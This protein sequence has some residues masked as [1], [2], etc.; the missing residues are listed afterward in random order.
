MH[1]YLSKYKEV[2]PWL[3]PLSHTEPIMTLPEKQ[4]E[5]TQ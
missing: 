1:Y 5:R 2:N 3:G 4:A